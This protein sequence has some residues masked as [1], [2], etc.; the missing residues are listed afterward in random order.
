MKH[1]KDEQINLLDIEN[2]EIKDLMAQLKRENLD[3]KV[4]TKHKVKVKTNLSTAINVTLN[5][6]KKML[7]KHT[8]NYFIKHFGIS[9]HAGAR[10]CRVTHK[11]V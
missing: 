11:I 5:V 9:T 8:K 6:M 3:L 7:W 2:K 4:S 10:V 1:E